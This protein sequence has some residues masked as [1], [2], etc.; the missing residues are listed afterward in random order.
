MI[1][2]CAVNETEIATGPLSLPYL[3]QWLPVRSLTATR[4]NECVCSREATRSRERQLG[5]EH[6]QVW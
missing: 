5:Q 4:N 3:A 1:L 2:T 6:R